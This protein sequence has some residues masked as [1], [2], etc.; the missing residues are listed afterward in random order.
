ME[1]NLSTQ[2]DLA[3][4]KT[5]MESAI[6]R[7]INLKNIGVKSVLE[8]CCGPSLKTLVAAYKMNGIS[9]W[10][11]D[12][13]N[14]WVNYYPQGYWIIKDCLKLNKD[15]IKFFNAVV[16]APPVTK[17]CTGKREDSLMIEQVTPSYYDF[18]EYIKD[19]KGIKALV[20]P[21]RS[22]LAGEDNNQYHK[23]INYIYKNYNVSYI[24]VKH[25]TEGKRKIRKY[26]DVYF[27]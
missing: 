10:G 8:L 19:Y 15:S 20:L 17:G 1:I 14:R 16:F 21:A 25:L 18:L 6:Q 7:A 11:N 26:V 23:L 3:T 5:N 13:D 27:Q 24:D 4:A 12:I 9:C 2:S 22:I